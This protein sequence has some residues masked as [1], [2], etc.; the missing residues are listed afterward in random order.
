TTNGINVTT[1]GT[2][3]VT[4][5]DGNGCSATDT[6]NINI[7]P[8][9]TV[10]ISG[11]DSACGSAEL[12][13]PAGFASY[14][15]STGESTSTITVTSSGTYTV[16][17]TDANGCTGFDDFDILITPIPA[18]TI[19]PQGP[20]TFCD[21]GNVML[22]ASPGSSYLWSTGETSQS[23]TVSA[24]GTFTV[25]V[26]DG[27]NCSAT[28][29]PTTVTVNPN[30]TPTITGPTST[31]AG[32]PVTLDAGNGFVSYLWS[33][34]ETSQTISVSPIFAASYSVTVTDAN[35][36]SG[37]D[38]HNVNV[39]SS[40]TA[41]ITAPAAVCSGSAG[42]TASVAA[43]SG[44]TYNWSIT[45]GTITSATNSDTIEFTAGA[46]G[47]VT[48]NVT[49]TIGACTS[50]GNTN[51]PITAPPVVTITGP[52]EACPAESFTLD[53]G[54]GFTTYL[55]SNGATSQSITVS[56]PGTYSV[57]VTDASGCS[58]SDSHVVTPKPL[59]SATIT[60]PSS[61]DPN[62]SGLTGSVA[63]QAGA[64]YLWSITNGTIDGGQGTNA[65]TF[66]TG[67]AGITKLIVTVTLNGCSSSSQKNMTINGTTPTEADIAISKSAPSSVQAGAQLTYTISV[68]NLGPA[69]APDVSF[70]DALPAG[71][72]LV[73]IN[74]GSFDC[75][76]FA[77]GIVCSGPLNAG[78][79]KQVFLTVNAPQQ[80]G[81]ITNGVTVDSSIPDP[82]GANDSASASTNVIAAPANCSTVPP[83]L[84]FPAGNA[85]VTSPVTFSWTAVEGAT[86]Y[87]V[88]LANAN[89]TFLAG[90]TNTTS[91]TKALTAE[92][93]NWY[94][95]AR[96][97]GNCTPLVS[98]QRT[99]T[100]TQ[101]GS[102][103]QNGPQLTAP[104]AG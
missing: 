35:G 9:P 30:P 101:S 62:T 92:T 74:E 90:T 79:T 40:P 39:T 99:F 24:S 32:T 61:A 56:S 100:V 80:A 94:V 17:V 53:A 84:L 45:N 6:H 41:T 4:V 47:Q 75:G 14:L 23:I 43:Q 91:L 34:G 71:T 85:N 66:T 18:A 25:T 11:P 21:G 46:T 81:T 98:A 22:M 73:S 13:A 26:T 82:N 33:T 2:Y 19:T 44:A 70:T 27:D 95:V 52:A 5:T 38:S 67:A 3:S 65:I 1:S 68:S 72:T 78:A 87:E 7:N 104:A 83:S 29:A 55:W 96:F 48:L 28:S 58:G 54:A 102:C 42:N 89:G 10:G 59:P 64:T 37:S 88:W 15:W 86:E 31:C 76:Q 57:T 20:T 36:C 97:A 51:I 16:T 12:I 93:S 8:S 60:A 49:I 50:T 69:D 103:T 63:A 77:V